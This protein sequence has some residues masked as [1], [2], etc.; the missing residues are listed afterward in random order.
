VKI[1]AP[2]R[3]GNQY[4]IPEDL[5]SWSEM[6][7]LSWTKNDDNKYIE[8]YSA[9]SPAPLAE[10]EAPIAA[11]EEAVPPPLPVA[12]PPI[13]TS[14]VPNLFGI[15]GSNLYFIPYPSITK[16]L[17]KFG[18]TNDELDAIGQDIDEYITDSEIAKYISIPLH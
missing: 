11:V 1:F 16:I 4:I 6:L 12:E 14:E 18:I 15:F 17:N 8:E 13:K 5:P 7:R 10:A 9:I 3:S 2:F